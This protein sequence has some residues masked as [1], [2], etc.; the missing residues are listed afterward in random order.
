MAEFQSDVSMSHIR[1]DGVFPPG[2]RYGWRISAPL[3]RVPFH[4]DTFPK[5]RHQFLKRLRSASGAS[6]PLW[7]LSRREFPI[8]STFRLRLRRDTP[9]WK[10]NPP[11]L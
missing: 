2:F 8:P 3:S 9:S 11:R 1:L 7:P 5:V 4:P 10:P 6:P